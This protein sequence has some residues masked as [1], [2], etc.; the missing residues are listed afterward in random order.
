MLREPEGPE[1]T[2]Q[3]PALRA[4][5]R[6]RIR[7]RRAHSDRPSDSVEAAARP[8][9]A[10]TLG[11]AENHP[12]GCATRTA[13]STGG[14]QVDGPRRRRRAGREAAPRGEAAA[15]LGELRRSCSDA[16]HRTLIKRTTGAAVHRSN[17]GRIRR[18]AAAT[19]QTQRC[20]SAEPREPRDDRIPGERSSGLAS[21]PAPAWPR[22]AP[23]ERMTRSRDLPNGLAPGSDD[24]SAR[25]HQSAATG[26]G[27]GMRSRIV[28]RAAVTRVWLRS[29]GALGFTRCQFLGPCRGCPSKR[30]SGHPC[31]DLPS[32]RGRCGARLLLH[33][34]GA[35]LVPERALVVE[36]DGGRR[37]QLVIASRL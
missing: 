18:R 19:A 12:S 33:W 34:L 1:R 20:G 11:T 26:P 4:R 24:R 6:H 3:R 23:R 7:E 2:A 9:L 22:R 31:P 28:D 29:C 10:L 32:E 17:S 25:N 14:R 37:H 30:R 36:R 16:P 27:V 15:A 5:A 35:D 8:D 21:M 13:A